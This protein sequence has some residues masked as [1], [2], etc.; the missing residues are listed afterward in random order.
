MKLKAETDVK[1]LISK[2]PKRSLRKTSPKLTIK[3]TGNP[4]LD[5]GLEL[6]AMPQN[7]DWPTD[8]AAQHDHYLYGAE[9]R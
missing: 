6:E 8:G 4:L 9:K 5:M 3:R 7:P 1:G 2:E